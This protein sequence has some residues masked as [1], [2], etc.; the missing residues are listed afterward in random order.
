MANA[1]STLAGAVAGSPALV[2]AWLALVAAF[3][4]GSTC[5]L[6]RLLPRAA[7]DNP[8]RRVAQ[9]S[10][11]PMVAALGNKGLDLLFAMVMLR[12]LGPVDAGKYAWLGV[13]IGYFDILLGFGMNTWLTREVARAP[14]AAGRGLGNAL[15]AR[16]L[17]WLGLLL[18]ALAMIG[19]LA[20][21][22]AVTPDVGLALLLL[23][24]AMA[25]SGLAA[26]LS[27][28]F[29]GRER[30][31]APA[32]VAVVTTVLK[33][34]LGLLALALGYGFV[35]LAAVALGVNLITL[36]V[37]A[38]LYGAFVGW[39]RLAF[40]P[41]ASLAL[42]RDA[43]PF[44]MND[45]LASLFFRL[46][47]LL[48]R[49]LAGNAALGWYS[50]AYRVPDG[51]N[52]IPANFTL[53]LFPLLARRAQDD[54]AALVRV[55]R[56]ALKVL[57]VLGLPL[58]MGIALLAEPLVYLFAGPRYVPE[59]VW[60]LQ[61]LI[62][63]LPFSFVNGVTQ[64]VLIA[65]DRQRFLTVAFAVATA[66]NLAANL[67]LIPRWGYLGAA[68]V[69]VLSEVVLLGPFWWAVTRSLPPVGLLAVAWRPALAALGMAVVVMPLAAWSWPLSIPIGAAF[70]L[71][72]LLLLRTF[73]ADDR[74]LL[75]RLRGRA[76][77]D[78]PVAEA[79]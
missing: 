61:V 19:P 73:D 66:F 2:A 42:A 63:F 54:R 30:M 36:A 14:E 50:A 68:L 40:A 55:Y 6:L 3:A 21:P 31:E 34:S 52:L 18:T 38:L 11:L 67:L 20:G 12:V 13:V 58:S 74:A 62:W 15:A 79:Q 44:M 45:L 39:P 28:L 71:A 16:A 41:R 56:R 25:P 76:S 29:Y 9:N 77:P 7:T 49:P 65:V 60:T 22:L 24:L 46:D 23:V 48:L 10:A 33:V 70:Y 72:I 75:Q 47:S 32:A 17:L 8:V 4:L 37:L 1:W 43:S 59:S 64:Y 35:G 26:A 69:T 5:L 53:A 57:L 51:L 78:Y 27:A